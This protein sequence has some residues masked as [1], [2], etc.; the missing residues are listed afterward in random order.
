VIGPAGMQ[1]RLS[2]KTKEARDLAAKF[3]ADDLVLADDYGQV[4]QVVA[5][6]IHA[7]ICTSDEAEIEIALNQARANAEAQERAGKDPSLR[8]AQQ[9][10]RLQQINSQNGLIS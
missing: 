6:Q 8:N 9:R 2:Y 5:N 10:A 3:D 4:V 1:F 7:V